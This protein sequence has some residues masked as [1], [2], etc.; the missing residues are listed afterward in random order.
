MT[1]KAR[2]ALLVVSGMTGRTEDVVGR[3]QSHFASATAAREQSVKDSSR[4]LIDSLPYRIQL[5]GCHLKVTD[6]YTFPS[7]RR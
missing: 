7:T 5:I 6:Y 3:G 1:V 2:E 4:A